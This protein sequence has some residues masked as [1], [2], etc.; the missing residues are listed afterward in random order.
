MIRRTVKLQVAVF[1]VIAAFGI[2]VIGS[3]YVGLFSGIVDQPYTVTA[4][5]HD[6]GGI[7]TN[8]EVTERGVAV[9][10]VGAL[11]LVP[12]GVA[13]QLILNQGTRIPANV[14]ADVADLSAVGEQY[15]NLRPQT[16]SGPYLS[17]GSRI[18]MNRTSTPLN[19][20]TILLSVDRLVNSVNTTDLA[21][22]IDQLGKAFAGTGP[23]LQRLIDSGNQ[24][25][26]TLHQAMPQ[27]VQLLNDGQTVL[28]TQQVV[29]GEFQSFA[30][31]IASLSAQLRASN[32]DFVRL[33]GNGISSAGQLQSLL[34]ANQAALPILLG[35]LV[36]GAQ[37]QDARLP[38][39]ANIFVSYPIAIA[40]GFHVVPG[41]GTS[42][43]GMVLDSSGQVCTNG[44]QSTPQRPVQPVGSTTPANTSAYCNEPPY[45]LIA[46]RGS[47]EAPRPPGDNTDPAL[48]GTLSGPSAGQSYDNPAA[49]SSS[50]AAGSTGAPPVA[51]TYDPYTG[52]LVAPGGQSMILGSTG[53]QS[54]LMGDASWKW[55]LLSPLQR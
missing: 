6:S 32:P 51:T 55:L 26:T 25:T 15:V 49:G 42:H 48:G 10:R 47:R 18:P 40:A 29:A 5:F 45:S 37:I 24:L 9:G 52:L 35:N 23:D 39:L 30:A 31:H 53:G 50:S 33:L 1:L 8:A 11:R 27:T 12:G 14:K 22:T 4:Y 44:Y 2:I 28:A 19:D 38:G 46:S 16:R 54:Q 43:F 36:T 17:A 34:H 13:V 7:F 3:R 20:A 21:T 41:D